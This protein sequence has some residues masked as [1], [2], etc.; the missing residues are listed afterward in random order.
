MPRILTPNLKRLVFTRM[1]REAIPDN[2]GFAD[3]I[4]F[5]TTPGMMASGWKS[6]VAWVDAAIQVVRDAAEPNPWKI[7]SDEEIAGVILEKL[8][9]AQQNKLTAAR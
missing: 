3:G 2:G 5:L 9:T 7:A 6:S 1:S 4:K 8:K